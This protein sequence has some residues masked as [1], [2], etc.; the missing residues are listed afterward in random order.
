M[1]LASA[2]AVV[3]ARLDL[4]LVR[5]LAERAQAVERLTLRHQVRVLRPARRHRHHDEGGQERPA[6]EEGRR[7]A[8][9]GVAGPVLPGQGEGQDE[10]RHQRVSSHETRGP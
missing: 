1:L 9:P 10:E 5:T 3:C 6:G 2:S 7:E 8:G 4:L